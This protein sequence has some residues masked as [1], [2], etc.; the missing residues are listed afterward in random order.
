MGGL[1]G[2][3]CPI[4]PGSPPRKAPQPCLASPVSPASNF[5]DG[6]KKFFEESGRTLGCRV[7]VLAAEILQGDELHPL[8][9]ALGWVGSTAQ[10]RLNAPQSASRPL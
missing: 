9:R 6:A 7:R 8:P 2:G 10:F 5:L 1:R 3:G 4:V